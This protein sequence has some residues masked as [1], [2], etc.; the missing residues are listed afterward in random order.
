MPGLYAEDLFT[1]GLRLRQIPASLK[2][3]RE[4]R[5]RG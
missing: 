2:S 3:M 4:L 5:L 1:K